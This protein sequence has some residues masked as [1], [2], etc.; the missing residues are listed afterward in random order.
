M[1]NDFQAI[2][3]TNHAKFAAADVARMGVGVIDAAQTMRTLL[4]YS[5][6]L[7][8]TYFAA[9]TAAY[10][11]VM[12]L[13]LAHYFQY[14][15]LAWTFH[16]LELP[17]SVWFFSMLAFLPLGLLAVLLLRRCEKQKNKVI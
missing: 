14:L 9:W 15:V 6:A 1:R 13:D 16:G 4:R 5:A 7:V 17:S 2:S 10:V 8:I 11:F 3:R 12:G